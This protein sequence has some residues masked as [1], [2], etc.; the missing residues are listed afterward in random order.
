MPKSGIAESDEILF[1]NYFRISQSQEA[2]GK[3]QGGS[4]RRC[5]NAGQA[6]LRR[7]HS[8]RD[9]RRVVVT[10]GKVCVAPAVPSTVS[11]SSCHL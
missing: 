5:W 8:S 4:V 6:G 2:E 11:T 1:F 9:W 3:E 10:L 7:P